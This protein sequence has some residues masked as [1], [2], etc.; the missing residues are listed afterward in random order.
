MG[1]EA[2]LTANEHREQNTFTDRRLAAR[3]GDQRQEGDRLAYQRSE[4]AHV[5]EQ[6]AAAH[7]TRTVVGLSL[8]PPMNWRWLSVG[9]RKVPSELG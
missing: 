5:D 6:H 3:H 2:D 8:N 1:H 9:M 7:L 4:E